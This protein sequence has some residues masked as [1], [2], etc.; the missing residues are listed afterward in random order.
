VPHQ[1][2]THKFPCPFILAVPA[3]REIFAFAEIMAILVSGNLVEINFRVFTIDH[4]AMLALVS[5]WSGATQR[6]ELA[7]F[8]L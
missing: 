1:T 2:S 5:L 6:I 4:I 8:S 3:L 7:A